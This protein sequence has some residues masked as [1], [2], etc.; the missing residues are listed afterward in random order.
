MSDRNDNTHHDPMKPCCQ[1]PMRCELVL[2]PHLTTRPRFP[3]MDAHAHFGRMLMGEDY[4]ARYDTAAV[5]S[6]MKTYGLT[7]VV[8]LDGENGRYFERMLRKTEGYEDFFHT[9]GN[10]DLTRFERPDF[11]K[12][13]Y[14][15]IKRQVGLGMKGLKFWKILGLAIQGRDGRYLRVDDKRLSVIWQTAAEF[16]IP[17]LIHIGDP[18]AFFRPVD[19]E[20]ERHTELIAHPDWSFCGEGLYSF[21]ELLEMQMTLLGDNPDTTFVVAHCGSYSEDLAA[22]GKWLDRYPNMLVDIA[23]RINDLGRQPYTAR[24]FFNRYSERILLGTDM[25]PMDVDRYPIYYRFLETFDEYF[26]YSTQPSPPQGEWKIYGLG[27][28]DDVLERVYIQNAKKMLRLKK[29]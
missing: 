12:Y 7:G 13:V 24:A 23:D 29:S 10:V 27:L 3:A 16:D 15:T 4:E 28:E 8:N 20:N 22:V 6:K 14:E 5:V 17:V 11:E 21:A 19:C 26:D 1:R 9:F 18:P 2:E 25:T